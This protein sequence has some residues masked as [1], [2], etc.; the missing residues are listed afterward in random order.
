VSWRN[1]HLEGDWFH[2]PLPANIE[3]HPNVYIE[4][5][6]VF[7][8]FFSELQ[9]GLTMGESSGAY[10]M[11]SLGTGPRGRIQVGA[12]TCL[13]STGLLADTSIS[14]GSHCLFAWGAMVTDGRIPETSEAGARSHA[15][16]ET[17]S[18]PLR[19]LRP[20][21]QP[22]PVYIG[23]NVWVGFDS[24]ICGNVTIGRGAIIGC[25]TVITEDVPP[26]ALVVGNPCRVLRFLEADD[27]EDVRLT[28]LREFG[29]APGSNR[30]LMGRNLEAIRNCIA[31]RRSLSSGANTTEARRPLRKRAEP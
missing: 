26:Y 11:S 16:I 18:D 5:S 8:A 31:V 9:P 21:T 3:L 23:E 29:L 14:I 7:A 27:T 20:M 30:H 4:S 17:A 13:N 25:K 19:R 28:A 6:Y 15:L 22:N 1:G 2:R 12:Y 10:G 24:V